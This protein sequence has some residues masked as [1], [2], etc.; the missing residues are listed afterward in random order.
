MDDDDSLPLPGNRVVFKPRPGTVKGGRTASSSGDMAGSS[1]T[2]G[3]DSAVSPRAATESAQACPVNDSVSFDS[4]YIFHFKELIVLTAGHR[5]S[6]LEI[7]LHSQMALNAARQCKLARL[8]AQQQ[9][10]LMSRARVV[11]VG[12]GP[13]T[14]ASAASRAVPPSTPKTGRA[15]PVSATP[16]ARPSKHS[17]PRGSATK[18][19]VGTGPRSSRAAASSRERDSR[20][21]AVRAAASNE[22]GPLSASMILQ[23]AMRERSDGSSASDSN[24]SDS[25]K[26]ANEAV[27]V[28]AA[29]IAATTPEFQPM[30]PGRQAAA[31]IP[32]AP[33]IGG[34]N[35]NGKRTKVDKSDTQAGHSV[36]R[37]HSDRKKASAAASTAVGSA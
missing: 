22:A 2:K 33:L 32:F 10:G 28:A 9:L 12:A 23:R 27:A 31:D 24:A 18:S 30:Q 35:T 29:A 11:P 14:P 37:A 6:A 15:T 1:S 4:S 25:A 16:R 5:P 20:G 34:Q 13:R 21:P 36:S 26:K 8:E 19:R 3:A 7:G 17:K